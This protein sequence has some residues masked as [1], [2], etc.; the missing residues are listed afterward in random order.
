MSHEWKPTNIRKEN[1]AFKLRISSVAFLVQNDEWNTKS[2]FC[3]RYTHLFAYSYVL[4]LKQLKVSQ[5]RSIQILGQHAFC[6]SFSS[7]S[8]QSQ[9]K[10]RR[11]GCRAVLC[12]GYHTTIQKLFCIYHLVIGIWSYLK[13]LFA[14]DILV[15]LIHAVYYYYILQVLDRVWNTKIVRQIKNH[16]HEKWAQRPISSK[17]NYCF[18]TSKGNPLINNCSSFIFCWWYRSTGYDY[19]SK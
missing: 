17:D 14:T 10:M 2:F 18:S 6:N 15:G 9:N 11:E 19:C 13:K 7:S 12:S 16:L 1:C 3:E 5:K 4:V 8:V